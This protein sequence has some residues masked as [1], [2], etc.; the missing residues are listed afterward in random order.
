MDEWCL[1]LNDDS[2]N[3]KA[4]LPKLIDY[5][6]F[7]H[8]GF[9]CV[10]PFFDGNGRMGRLLCNIPLLKAGLP[11]LVIRNESRTDYFK[12]LQK[13][14]EATPVPCKLTGIW[15]A[16]DNYLDKLKACCHNEYAE[17]QELMNQI[18]CEQQKRD[19]WREEKKTRGVLGNSGL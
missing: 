1:A 15:P 12:A 16:G 6:A 17:T 5:Y 18:Q 9:T 14:S 3:A 8:A 10:H 19:H 7:L 11:P 13:Y 4:D 2:L